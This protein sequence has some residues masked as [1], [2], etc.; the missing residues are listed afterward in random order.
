M[1]L[2]LTEDVAIILL[3]IALAVLFAYI[4]SEFFRK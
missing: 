1:D 3:Y 4:V 2:T